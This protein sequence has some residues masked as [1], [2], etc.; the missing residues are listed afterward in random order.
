MITLKRNE[1]V[2]LY[3]VE[4]ALKVKTKETPFI[5]ILI[6]A[7]EQGTIDAIS[8]KSNLLNTLPER[9]CN[10]L[11]KRLTQQGYLSEQTY[12]S[13]SSFQL[14][15]LGETCAT[16]KS[17]WIG[18]KGV[19]NVFVSKSNLIQQRVI[20]IDKVDRPED[21]RD[22]SLITTPEGIQQYE[23]QI[24]SINK[25]EVLIEDIEPKCFQL[26]PVNTVLEIQTAG[27]ETALKFSKDNQVLF[28]TNLEVDESGIRE[29]LL[30]ACEEFEYSQDKKAIL[31]EF[32]KDDLSFARKARIT[33][34]TFLRNQFNPVELENITHIP[35]N[36]KSADLWL[37]EL[38]YKGIDRYFLDENSF[39][40]FAKELAKP[41]STHYKV[42]VP[43]R[44]ELAEIFSNREDAFYQIAKLETIDFLNY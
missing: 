38:L 16:E 4:L 8:V 1:E 9:A 19:Y 24:L 25:K 36:K 37:N 17:F 43:N 12:G 32:S 44:K 21:N 34:P 6:L 35:G 30:T 20:K 41:I 40:E 28:Q 15:P 31:S 29:Q 22:N 39:D 13:M 18:E 42:K 5:A 14:T 11:L 27:S 2:G 26:K 10:N 33:K 7:Q 3:Q 23:N